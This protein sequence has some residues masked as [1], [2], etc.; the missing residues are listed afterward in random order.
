MHGKA[1]GYVDGSRDLYS[2]QAV[3]FNPPAHTTALRKTSRL[4]R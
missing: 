2:Y 4:R 1:K 3:W